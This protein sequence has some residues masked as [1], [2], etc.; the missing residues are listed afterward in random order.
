MCA[1]SPGY[2]GFRGHVVLLTEARLG[3]REGWL[4]ARY[5]SAQALPVPAAKLDIKRCTVVRGQR[6][7]HVQ[8]FVCAF[9]MGP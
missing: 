8:G 9:S 6:K 2:D 3:W 7:P 1:K 5:R 4:I